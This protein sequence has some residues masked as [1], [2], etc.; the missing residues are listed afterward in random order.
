MSLSRDLIKMQRQTTVAEVSIVHDPSAETTKVTVYQFV[1]V[2]C[3]N[4]LNFLTFQLSLFLNNLIYS[5][6]HCFIIIW[7]LIAESKLSHS[8]F[9]MFVCLS[10]NYLWKRQLFN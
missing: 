7:R 2:D 6:I 9:V 1:H 5:H 4:S 8:P 10:T 3:Q